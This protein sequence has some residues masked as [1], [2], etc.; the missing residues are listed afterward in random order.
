MKKLILIV[1]LIVNMKADILSKKQKKVLN[2]VREIARTMPDKNGE[3]YENTLAAI[4]ITESSAGKHIVGDIKKGDTSLLHASLGHMQVRIATVKYISRFKGFKHIRHWSKEKIKNK[5]LTDM[6]FSIKI[7][8]KYFLINRNRFKNNGYFKA[9][10]LY[11]GGLNNYPYVERVLKNIKLVK[12]LV[13][14]GEIV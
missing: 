4:S 2:L 3:T 14:K 12:L 13:K 5:L 11:N 1:L 8:L 9:I 7:A 6:E 10:S